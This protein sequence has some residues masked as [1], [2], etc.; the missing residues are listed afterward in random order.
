MLPPLEA[1]P[2]LPGLVL[3]GWTTS[4]DTPQARLYY[5]DHQVHW[6]LSVNLRPSCTSILKLHQAPSRCDCNSFFSRLW[7]DYGVP[8]LDRSDWRSSSYVCVCAMCPSQSYDRATSSS[9]ADGEP[10][11]WLKTIRVRKVTARD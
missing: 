11:C 7:S 2:R 8:I 1:F 6:A 3:R 5:H 4:R 10:R 9:S